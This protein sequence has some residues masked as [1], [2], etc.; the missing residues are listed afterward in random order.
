M[1]EIRQFYYSE[2]KEISESLHMHKLKER[3]VNLY[4]PSAAMFGHFLGSRASACIMVPLEGKLKNH[5]CPS[6]LFSPL[7]LYI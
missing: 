4:F 1:S 5:E 7:A 6:F 3:K 2:R